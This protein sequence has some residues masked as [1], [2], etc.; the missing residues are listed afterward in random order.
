MHPEGAG[1]VVAGGDYATLAGTSTDCNG[2]FDQR[3][4][5]AHF[6]RCVKTIAVAMDDLTHALTLP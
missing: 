1:V 3:W 2:Q 4:V 5:I 6:N